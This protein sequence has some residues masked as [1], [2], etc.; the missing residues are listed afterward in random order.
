MLFC[1]KAESEREFFDLLGRKRTVCL[2]D[3]QIEVVESSGYRHIRSVK[4]VLTQQKGTWG[5]PWLLQAK[6]DVASDE[7]LWGPAGRG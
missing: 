4:Q 1:R 3:Q 5:M 7:T 2:S 6:K